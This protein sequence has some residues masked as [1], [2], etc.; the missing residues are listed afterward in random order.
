LSDKI[1]EKRKRLL[2]IANSSTKVSMLSKMRL[3]DP[4]DIVEILKM[5]S[6][7]REEME[8]MDYKG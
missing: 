7:I 8:Q 6:D 2:A 3:I 5:R 4:V 1:A